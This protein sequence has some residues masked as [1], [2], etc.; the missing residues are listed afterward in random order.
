MR[1]W[2]GV[3]AAF[4]FGTLGLPTFHRPAPHDKIKYGGET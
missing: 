4:H 3:F 2:A 1:G